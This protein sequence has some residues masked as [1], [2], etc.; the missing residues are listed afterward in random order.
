MHPDQPL[1]TIDNLREEFK[2]LLLKIHFILSQAHDWKDTLAACKKL[3][4]DK[5]VDKV[6][7]FSQEELTEIDNSMNFKQLFAVDHYLSWDEYSI[8]SEIIDICYSNKAEEE[9][10]KYEKKMAGV[11]I[12]ETTSSAKPP[13][14][15]ESLYVIIDNDEHCIELTIE[16]FKEI[17]ISIFDNL[18][19]NCYCTIEQKSVQNHSLH[20]E[21]HVTRQVVPHMIKVAKE[22]QAFFKCNHF[23]SMK[24][25]KELIFDEHTKLTLVSFMHV[26][27]HTVSLVVKQQS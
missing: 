26:Y 25:G 16:K 12:K 5:N 1:R 17:K 7:L 14:G 21:W 6:P 19:T 3:C 9:I 2:H 13:P 11:K 20:L 8:L 4:H 23:S 22:Q 18:N 27:V 24:I 10:D 15:F